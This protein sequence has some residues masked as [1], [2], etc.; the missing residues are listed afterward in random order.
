MPTIRGSRGGKIHVQTDANAYDQWFELPSGKRI[1]VVTIRVGDEGP[2][3]E[4]IDMTPDVAQKVL[5][6]LRIAVPN[7]KKADMARGERGYLTPGND[8]TMPGGGPPVYHGPEERY[9][10]R[11]P[12]R[13][14]SHP[15]RM[16]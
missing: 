16:K 1:M 12:V 15:R 7:A 2:D 9:G 13:V 14:R 8:P 3:A 11:R 10:G 5:D 6:D 4:Y